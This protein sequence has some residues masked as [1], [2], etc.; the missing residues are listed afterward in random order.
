MKGPRPIALTMKI[1]YTNGSFSSVDA[2]GKGMKVNENIEFHNPLSNLYG[3]FVEIDDI[4]YEHSNKM[5]SNSIYIYIV[6]KR[7]YYIYFNAYVKR[8]W[9][10][11]GSWEVYSR[12]NRFYLVKFELVEDLEKVNNGGPWFIDSKL[13]FMKKWDANF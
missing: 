13:I 10:S 7:P 8:E 3:G 5:W 2:L 1:N 12:G 9:Q 11:K 4:D 6:S